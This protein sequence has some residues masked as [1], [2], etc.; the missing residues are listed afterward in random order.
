MRGD[1]GSLAMGAATERPMASK[2]LQRQLLALLLNAGGCV[3]RILN[4][5]RKLGAETAKKRAD[6]SNEKKR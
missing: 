6:H 1:T 4:N 3:R 5:L 2:L